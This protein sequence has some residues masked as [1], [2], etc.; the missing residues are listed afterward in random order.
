MT[1]QEIIIEAKKR[2]ASDVH[3]V[4][5]LPVRIRV[6]GLLENFDENVLS[7]EDCER[8]VQEI[9]EHKVVDEH[10]FAILIE[11]IRCRINIFRQQGHLSMAIRLLNDNIPELESLGLPAEISRFTEFNRG[12]VIVTGETG[13]GKSTTLAALLNKINKEDAVH[14]ITLEDPIEYVYKPQKALINQREVGSDTKSFESGMEAI[15]REDPDII[16]IG[17][18]RS[19]ATIEAALTAAET[20]HLV[21]A[22]L[23]TNSCAD[24]ID[25]IVEIFPAEKQKQIRR[26][27]SMTL[28]GVICQQL[29]PNRE[30]NGRVLAYELMFVNGAIRNLIREGKTPQISSTISITAEQ[31]N[32]TMDRCLIKLAMANKIS[33]KKAI[34]CAVDKEY[35]ISELNYT[36]G[37]PSDMIF[38]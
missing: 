18:M 2:K 25:R 17:E 24:T 8:Y 4:C 29:I 35:V 13:S 37:K 21:F 11:D 34:E 10:D 32:I 1:I 36:E 16:L 20:G 19:Q 27:L 30:G 23:H 22:T 33:V 7:H 38:F 9:T 26:Q 15:L 28:D 14:I 6:H 12:I 31:G 5:G 3:V